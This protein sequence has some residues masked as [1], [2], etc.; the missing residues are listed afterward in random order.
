[1][2]STFT[3]PLRLNTRQVPSNDGS[4]SPDNTGAAVI[5][6]QAAI[7]G[8]AATTI[9][10]PAGSIVHAVQGYV[11]TAAGTP[12]TPNV[13]IDSTVVGTLSDDAGVNAATLTG[14]AKLANVGSSNATLSF[15]A[16]A[17]AVGVLSVTY[18]G[19]NAD[20]TITPYGSGLSNS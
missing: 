10:L 17:D 8:G 3:L 2:S 20:G 12:G 6:Q 1:M 11:T 15:T 4:L 5:T 13:T 14:A 18:T 9:V 16:G 19:R 7:V